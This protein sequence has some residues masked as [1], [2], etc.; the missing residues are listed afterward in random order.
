MGL[1]DMELGIFGTDG[2]VGD[3]RGF[4]AISFFTLTAATGGG[5]SVSEL[6][7]TKDNDEVE[8][9]TV[10]FDA[11]GDEV[12]IDIKSFKFSDVGKPGSFL[13]TT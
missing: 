10:G 5:A 6:I 11:V 1:N 13:T 4:S 12:G 9:G 7:G 2:V 8:A 3:T